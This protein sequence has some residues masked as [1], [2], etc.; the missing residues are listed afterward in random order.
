MLCVCVCKR[1]RERERQLY[2]KICFVCSLHELLHPLRSNFINTWQQT[3]RSVNTTYSTIQAHG[4]HTAY[5]WEWDRQRDG[6]GTGGP[7][8]G[9][10]KWNSNLKSMPWFTATSNMCIITWYCCHFSACSNCYYIATYSPK[11]KSEPPM[12]L[13]LPQMRRKQ[14]NTHIMTQRTS[15]IYGLRSVVFLVECAI[16]HRPAKNARKL[17]NKSLKIIAT[18]ILQL[19]MKAYPCLEVKWPWPLTL[20]KRCLA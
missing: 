2:I 17:S 6:T 19:H 4:M 16:D 13:S 11:I 18:V 14:E 1:E 8:G 5:G 10:S 7:G 12:F 15:V 9:K 3:D 20:L